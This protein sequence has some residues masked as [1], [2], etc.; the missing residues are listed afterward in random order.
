MRNY[1]WCGSDYD[2][3]GNSRFQAQTLRYFVDDDAGTI[4]VDLDSAQMAK[5]ATFTAK[6]SYGY[7][8]F[9]NFASSFLTIF[10]VPA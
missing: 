4:S 8:N 7:P 5:S 9:D 3:R 2:A 10:Q 6:A 1:T